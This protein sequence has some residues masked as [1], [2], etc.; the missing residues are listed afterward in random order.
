MQTE[1][2]ITTLLA[3]AAWLKDPVRAVASQSL[4]DVYDALKYY[5]KRKLA[6]NDAA[7]TALNSAL[8]KPTS[9][10]RKAVLVEETEPFALHTDR[11]LVDLIERIGALLPSTSGTGSQN[12]Q[13][14]GNGN[15]VNFAGRDLV[16]TERHIQRNVITPDDRHL[17]REQRSQLLPAI[18]ELA[19][20]LAGPDG[21]PN[22]GGV[23]RMLQRRFDVPSYLLIPREKYGDALTFLR[24]Q[25]AI[26][27]GTL[28]RRNPPAF[29]QDRF[30]AIFSRATE[31]GWSRQQVYDFAGERLK[32]KRPLTSL[33][34]LGLAQLEELSAMMR[35]AKPAVGVA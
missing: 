34:Q 28:R 26:R 18:H 21:K 14:E 29:A 22:L 30:R 27:R 24:Q 6:G 10:G 9:P 12:W 25:R 13:V 32:L 2:I 17:A 3:A 7:G 15:H 31:L 8:E 16:V 11:E 23:H 35:N 5:L 4:R 33:K 20:R 1:S 19:E